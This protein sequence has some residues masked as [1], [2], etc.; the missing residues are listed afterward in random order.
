MKATDLLIFRLT[1]LEE[2]E[3]HDPIIKV[4]MVVERYITAV[5][6]EGFI[7]YY[8]GYASN[9]SAQLL[10]ALQ[11]I[12]SLTSMRIA[13]SSLDLFLGQMPSLEHDKRSAQVDAVVANANA[14]VVDP[15]VI[16]PWEAI[17]VEF[18]ADLPDLESEHLAYILKHRSLVESF[19][20]NRDEKKQ[21]AK[22]LK[23]INR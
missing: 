18:V 15:W 21:M 12:K 14:N 19:P 7:G 11:E 13:R 8:Y 9:D 5:S 6:S 16:D 4:I 20:E 2:A 3:H 10:G 22:L 1:D 23:K 17:N